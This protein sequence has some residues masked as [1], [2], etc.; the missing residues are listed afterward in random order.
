ML[1]FKAGLSPVWVGLGVG[2]WWLP[3]RL[4]CLPLVSDEGQ[5]SFETAKVDS[6]LSGS[7]NRLGTSF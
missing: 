2:L 3:V 7:E 6:S 5:L 1:P 4:A